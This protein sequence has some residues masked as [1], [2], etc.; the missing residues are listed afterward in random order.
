MGTALPLDGVKVVD[1][2]QFL[3]GPYCTMQLADLGA[4]V[5]KVERPGGGD[6]ARDMGPR[7]A[8][9]SY[10]FQAPNR[11]KRSIAIDLRGDAGRGLARELIAGADVV[12]ESFRPGVADR[13]GIGYAAVGPASPD[14]VYCSISGFGQTGPI[15]RRPGF[16]IIAQGMGGFMRMTG[17]PGGAPVKVGVAI[18]DLAAGLNASIA[19]LAAYVHRLRGG[20]GQYIDISLLDAGIGLTVW[21]SAAYFG[22][23][24]DA[25][26]TGSRHRKIAPY[27]A[28]PTSDGY[29][30]VGANNQKLW[31]VFCTQV[32]ERPDL[33]QRTEYATVTDRITRVDQLEAELSAVLRE[34][35]TEHWAARLDSAGVPGGP[36][37][38]Y[39]E[40][41]QQEQVLRRGMV[42][43]VPHPTI[44]DVRVLGPVAKMSRT[45]PTVRSAA[46]LLGADTDAV[47]AEIG[48]SNADISAFRDAG[49][50]A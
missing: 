48:Y 19:I 32:L 10:S 16:D 15:S 7:V 34:H 44:G 45:T 30:T 21:E 33:P 6:D 50:V 13:L 46:P 5:I 14:L 26:A 29:V 42:A 1:F 18:T 43:Q 35:P 38:T 31:E 20:S 17:E 4:D 9:E 47:L 11:N 39:A 36:V 12:V 28:F 8:G 3:A 23:G 40:A 2:S 37:L 25:T 49:T 24:E 27:Q 41:M 22:G